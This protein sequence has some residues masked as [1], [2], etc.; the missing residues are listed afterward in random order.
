MF[1]VRDSQQDFE[2]FGAILK[3]IL[4][5]FGVEPPEPVLAELHNVM[6]G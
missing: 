4:E 2:N 3:P 6:I 1:D 5:D